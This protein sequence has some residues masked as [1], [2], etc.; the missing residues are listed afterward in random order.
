MKEWVW[1][2]GGMTLMG[3]TEVLSP[4]S[5]LSTTIPTWTALRL[6]PGL[7]GERQHLTVWAVVT[8][9]FKHC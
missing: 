7:R 1:S 5:T 9:G 8:F 3:K 6:K 4:I 2:T